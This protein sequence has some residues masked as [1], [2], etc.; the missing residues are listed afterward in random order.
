[1]ATYVGEPLLRSGVVSRET[2]LSQIVDA[3]RHV[4]LSYCDPVTAISALSGGDQLRL[5]AAR[6][7]I[8]NPKLIII[9]D[10][11][12]DR[13]V[14]V[15]LQLLNLFLELQDRLEMT[16]VVVSASLSIAETIC[17]ELI[18]LKE[19]RVVESGTTRLC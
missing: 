9:D 4:G 10:P 13:D 12:W 18:I 6:I 16:M 2:A 14:S 7:I 17:D 1:M 11:A 15:Q 19:G 3:L 8:T 5:A